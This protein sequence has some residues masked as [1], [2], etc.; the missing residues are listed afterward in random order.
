MKSPA[1]FAHTGNQAVRCH[2]TE[3]DAG[4]AELTHVAFGTA[5]QLTAVVLADGAGILRKLLKGNDGLLHVLGFT[6]TEIASSKTNPSEI[7]LNGN[8]VY[9][10]SFAAS[11]ASSAGFYKVSKA[12][13]TDGTQELLLGYDT[14]Y[15][16]TCLSVTNGGYLYFLN[17]I[18]K[19]VMGDAHF[20]QLNL[21][22]NEVAKIA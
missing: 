12:A 9:Y 2:L 4:D 6:G 14:K 19:L 10:Y 15:Y 7:L 13:T 5:G 20:Y 17:Y 22:N 3:V 21:E 11:A 16:G 1:G 18:P 8:Y